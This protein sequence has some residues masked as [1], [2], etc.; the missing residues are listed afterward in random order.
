MF[1]VH[2]HYEDYFN[3]VLPKCLQLLWDKQNN[4][5]FNLYMPSVLYVGHR[6]IA[7]TQIRRHRMRRLIRVSTVS[8]HN[9]LLKLV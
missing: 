1:L 2:F 9:F 6:Q 7:Q 8:L 5:I 3:N 4:C